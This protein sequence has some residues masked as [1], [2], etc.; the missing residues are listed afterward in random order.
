MFRKMV[1][2]VIALSLIIGAGFIGADSAPKVEA[3]ET[4]LPF[5]DIEKHWAKDNIISAY[6]S[7]L[8][9]GFPDGTFRPND[10]VKADQF[11]AMMLKAFSK[12]TDGKTEFDED[13]IMELA[14]KRP[15]T[16]MKLGLLVRNGFDFKPAK[17]GYWAKPF[18]DLL[19]EVDYLPTFDEIFPK[20]YDVYK[21]Q[22]KREQASYLLGEWY[23]QYDN[24]LDPYYADFVTTHS[25]LKD[26][27]TFTNTSVKN[28]RAHVLLAGI[29]TGYPNENFYP[30]RFV[31]RA[32]ALTLVQRLCDKTL[33]TPY[34]PDLTGQ[35]Y[36]E[37][38]GNIYLI[39][40]KFKYD[41]YNSMAELAKKHVTNGY[42]SQDGLGFAV[43]DSKETAD[44]NDFLFRLGDYEKLAP[45]D[46]SVGVGASTTRLLML[47]YP[48]NKKMPYAASYFDS[49]LNLFTGNDKGTELKAKIISIEKTVGTKPVEFIFNNRKFSLYAEGEIFTLAMK[50]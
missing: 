30:H 2:L 24:T 35:Y 48:I 29:M 43:L 14:D 13:W 10:V 44:K 38:Q 41:M 26:F 42:I 37:V 49:L 47:V 15:D 11:V 17:S 33:R 9:E 19:Y 12:T 40:D 32:E 3:A 20:N 39:S 34:Q 18:I 7:G 1:N 23:T 8:I 45:V 25:G 16:A 31:T 50:Y 22:I 28:Y 27:N 5:K 46:L 21:K 4:K 6:N 36:A